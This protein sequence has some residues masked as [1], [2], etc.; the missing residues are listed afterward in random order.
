MRFQAL[1][2]AL[3]IGATLLV[4]GIALARIGFLVDERRA[5]QDQAVQSVQQS[6]AGAQTLLGPLLQR[7]CSEEWEVIT[8]EGKE[9]RSDTARREFSLHLVPSRLLVTSQSQTD[10]RYRGLFKVNG[11]SARLDLGAQWSDLAALQPRRE[12]AASRLACGPV[13]VWIATSDVRGLRGAQISVDGRTLAV[14][15]GTGNEAYTHGLRAELPGLAIDAAAPGPLALQAVIDLVGTAEIGL[16][17]VAEATEWRLQ[18]DWPHP[19]FGGRFLPTRREVTDSGFS[20][21]WSD[22]SLATTA[23]LA[24]VKGAA[25]APDKARAAHVLDTL[26]VA[27]VDPVNPYMLSDRAIKYGLLFVVLTFTAVLM[28][29][30]LARGRVRRVH[31]IQYALVGLALCLFFLLLLSLSE[32]LAFGIAYAVASAACVLL[33]GFYGRHMLGSLRDGLLFGAGMALLYGLLYLL[34]LREQTALVLGSV[35]L[36]GAL[37]AVMLLTRRVDW[38]R[39]APLTGTDRPPAPGPSTV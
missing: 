17:P 33:L 4:L 1:G 7:Q 30:T 19:S 29:E 34:L 13:S 22:S 39:L 36:F 18:S 3:A 9:R 35:G 8:G 26:S 10:L 15:P 28:A 5:Y 31:P 16:V 24:V 20:A 6:H 23:P 27:F 11:Y 2:K 25:M 32:H 37:A 12:H 38:Y 21:V 14:K